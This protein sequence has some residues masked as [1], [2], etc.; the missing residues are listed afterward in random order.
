MQM[1]LVSFPEMGKL[2]SEGAAGR[3]QR[4]L[5]LRRWKANRLVVSLGRLNREREANGEAPLPKC[6]KDSIYEHY[7]KEGRI[8]RLET[9]EAMADLLEVRAEW[10]AFGS[11]PME[12]DAISDPKVELYL[13]DGAQSEGYCRE[14]ET[15]ADRERIRPDFF[16]G[17][18]Q[19]REQIFGEFVDSAQHWFNNYFSRLMQRLR[20]KDDGRPDSPTMRGQLAGVA[21]DETIALASKMSEHYNIP[22]FVRDIFGQPEGTAGMMLALGRMMVSENPE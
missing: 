10:L 19:E 1:C 5:E 16:K 4:A 6:N 17:F 11:G 15:S 22:P 9:L 20:D 21:L 2:R 14:P 7:L 13:I 12:R 3:L 8:P 18:T